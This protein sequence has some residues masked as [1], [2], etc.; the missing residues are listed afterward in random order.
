[1]QAIKLS[2]LLRVSLLALFVFI[3]SFSFAQESKSEYKAENE[4]WLVNIDEAYAMSQKTG[5]PILANFT[6][7]DWCGWCKRLTKSVFI[8]DEFKEWAEENVVLLELDFPRRKQ[9]PK[10]IKAQNKSLQKAFAVRGYPTI[11][12]FDLAKKENGEFAI[13]SLGRTGYTKTVKEFT[14]G[15]DEMLSRRESGE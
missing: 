10:E 8:H 5:K 2:G 12:V 4:G 9:L 15:I 1:M 7:S 6:G 14:D 3:S 13:S 11:F